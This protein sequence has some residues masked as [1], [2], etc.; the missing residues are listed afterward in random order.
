[1]FELEAGGT[2]DDAA[3][4]APLI[5]LLAFL[6]TSDEATFVAELPGRLDIDGFAVYLAMMDLLDNFDDIDGPGNNSTCT[7]R[8][9]LGSSRSCP[10]T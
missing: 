2:G 6:D 1:V 9:T 3:D 7:P 4:L 8:R 5:D 10:G